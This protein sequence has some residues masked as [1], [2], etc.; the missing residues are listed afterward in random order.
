LIVNT[1]K[2]ALEEM[3]S[4]IMTELLP[5]ETLERVQYSSERAEKELSEIVKKI[6]KQIMNG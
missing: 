6:T 3:R 5:I 4:K 2:S 1:L